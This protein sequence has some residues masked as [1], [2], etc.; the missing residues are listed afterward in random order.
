MIK[1]GV[2][3]ALPTAH[4]PLENR[5]F[6]WNTHGIYFYIGKTFRPYLI[7]SQRKTQRE[8]HACGTSRKPRS[9]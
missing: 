5:Y 1:R 2:Y 4:C 3:S 6:L 7:T 8:V 9:C